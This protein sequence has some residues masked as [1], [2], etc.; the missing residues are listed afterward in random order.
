VDEIATFSGEGHE[1]ALSLDT[2]FLDGLTDKYIARESYD[3][4]EDAYND[5]DGHVWVDYKIWK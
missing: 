3:K 1:Q 2:F 4:G 5:I